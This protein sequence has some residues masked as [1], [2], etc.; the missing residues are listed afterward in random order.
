[1]E[2]TQITP[3]RRFSSEKFSRNSPLTEP[4]KQC[5]SHLPPSHY[6]SPHLFLLPQLQRDVDT[7]RTL[8]HPFPALQA[9]SRDTLERG[10]TQLRAP[11]TPL[12]S[13]SVYDLPKCAQGELRK[14][15]LRVLR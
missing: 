3:S 4:D 12:L 10:M 6:Q 1:M 7:H 2:R 5:S 15:D 11:K 14:L 13:L 8:H 9:P